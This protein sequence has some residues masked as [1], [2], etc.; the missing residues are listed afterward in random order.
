[1]VSAISCVLGVGAD[2]EVSKGVHAYMRWFF[3]LSVDA[4]V[5]ES[6]K[7]LHTPDWKSTTSWEEWDLLH[8][9]SKFTPVKD[10]KGQEF[11]LFS[12]HLE[13]IRMHREGLL[14]L[15]YPCDVAPAQREAFAYVVFE[16]YE[17]DDAN[18]QRTAG[19]KSGCLLEKYTC[20]D[21]QHNAPERFYRAD[22]VKL[23]FR[24]LLFDVFAFSNSLNPDLPASAITTRKKFYLDHFELDALESKDVVWHYEA[25]VKMLQLEPMYKNPCNTKDGGIQNGGADDGG[26]YDAFVDDADDYDDEGGFNDFALRGTH[27]AE[28][29]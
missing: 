18:S 9:A 21:P 15:D 6:Y 3:D 19:A 14:K 17:Y 20:F 16:S 1:M 12:V 11:L 27:R 24:D 22:R 26:V 13:V 7:I 2:R 5:E 23:L 8:E 25:G 29:V 10:G 4:A 28:R